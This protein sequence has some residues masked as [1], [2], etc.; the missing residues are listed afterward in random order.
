MQEKA[1][2]MELFIQLY[3]VIFIRKHSCTS[4]KSL[5]KRKEK[6]NTLRERQPQ[7][8]G[9]VK[10]R[11]T[12]PTTTK[13][14]QMHS[15]YWQ[16]TLLYEK[17]SPSPLTHRPEWHCM[18]NK[19][20]QKDEVKTTDHWTEQTS[21]TNNQAVNKQTN[22]LIRREEWE[23]GEGKESKMEA[24]QHKR[25]QPKSQTTTYTTKPGRPRSLQTC[26]ES[27]TPAP[28]IIFNS[29]YKT[30]IIHTKPKKSKKKR[31]K[32]ERKTL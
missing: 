2:L 20:Q 28:L 5:P 10:E 1:A 30:T 21:T 23:G 24:D 6:G 15:T 25:K 19:K 29:T 18:Q 31:Q 17:H 7:E 22:R 27:T 9:D 8:R 13:H 3:I 26:R 12:V 4:T 14:N 16:H 11:L 32:M